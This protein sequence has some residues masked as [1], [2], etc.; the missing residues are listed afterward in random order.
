M[1]VCSICEEI[2]ESIRVPKTTKWDDGRL[3][4]SCD[5]INVGWLDSVI[6]LSA[7]CTF[8]N[9]ITRIWNRVY[10]QDTVA[11]TEGPAYTHYVTPDGPQRIYVFLSN[12]TST[13][14]SAT[15]QRLHWLISIKFL[16]P[17][18]DRPSELV[19][20]KYPPNICL[21]ADDAPLLTDGGDGKENF[22]LGRL[23]SA[24]GYDHAFA[25]SCYEQCIKEHGD[26]CVRPCVGYGTRNITLPRDE[27]LVGQLRIIDVVRQCVV[28]AKPPH[29][30]YAVL[31]YV[32]GQ[33]N[34]L[35]LTQSTCG[36]LAKED[37]LKRFRQPETIAHAIEVTAALGLRY[38]WIDALCIIQDSTEDK[39]RVL[40]NMDTIYASASITIVAAGAR[41]A[42]GGLWDQQRQQQ[43]IVEELGGLCFVATEPDVFHV[44]SKSLW[45]TRGWTYQ[46]LVLSRRL[47]VFSE[48][49]AYFSCSS[50][51]YAEDSVHRV[52]T[53]GRHILEYGVDWSSDVPPPH[54]NHPLLEFPIFWAHLVREYTRRE[55][56]YPSDG[57]DAAFGVMRPHSHM[58]ND[59]LLCGLLV[60]T[61]FEYGLLWIPFQRLKRRKTESMCQWP[62]WS[63]AGW[64]GQV[65]YQ[66][67]ESHEDIAT[68]RAIPN[69]RVKSVDGPT[70]VIYSCHNDHTEPDR[71]SLDT[72]N[73][74]SDIDHRIALLS[75]GVLCFETMTA[76]FQISRTHYSQLVTDDYTCSHTGLY[77]I[78]STNLWIGSVH[79]EHHIA[80]E[81]TAN[82]VKHEFI[83]LSK[84]HEHP[85][86]IPH[87]SNP[88]QDH[89]DDEHVFGFDPDLLEKVEE[90]DVLA[91][92]NVMLVAYDESSDIATRVGIGQIRLQS[93][94]EVGPVTKWIRLA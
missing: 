63:W 69:W 29:M 74:A 49:Q 11:Q 80:S 62:T 32:W 90:N 17:R 19:T 54:S 53:D 52:S 18:R 8:C 39:V 41:E 21:L 55:L 76:A 36:M 85:W 25:R 47:L 16:M 30:P 84:E 44:L 70:R 82:H 86:H 89:N 91:V 40:S 22:F 93:F 31:S 45:Y 77:K 28:E 6:S 67:L 3:A 4:D 7:I 12:L 1:H 60:A 46:E 79:L 24:S 34:F 94:D 56:T 65:G 73:T 35:T 81:L 2:L 50:A 92:Y 87:R 13:H 78:F 88:N 23:R 57:L 58:V 43:Q 42:D 59:R 14:L 72:P 64:V 51:A 83:V 27:P 26:P 37:A 9:L 66:D 20:T 33:S 75:A 38:L 10:V 15:G 71:E 48:N 68:R 61:L 5:S